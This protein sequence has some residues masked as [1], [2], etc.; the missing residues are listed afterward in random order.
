[1]SLACHVGTLRICN[2]VF[3]HG[4]GRGIGRLVLL[5]GS[6]EATD[7]EVVLINTQTA[8][9]VRTIDQWGIRRP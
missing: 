3:A 2:I 6:W 8:D 4:G 7:A 5:A 1:L 9:V